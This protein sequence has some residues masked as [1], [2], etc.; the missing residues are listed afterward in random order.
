MRIGIL[1]LP[2]HTNYGGIL[3]AYALQTVLERMGHKVD[4]IGTPVIVKHLPLWRKILSVSK[5]LCQRY[6]LGRKDIL[7]D[8]E[9]EEYKRAIATRKYT[10]QF[11][12]KYIHTRKVYRLQEIQQND[13]DAII[14]GSDQ[15][16][17]TDY[18]QQWKQQN[19]DDVYLGFTKDW[20]L[21]RIAYAASFG[22]D[23]VELKG[24]ELKLCKEAISKFNAISV[25]EENGVN[26]CREIFGVKATVM[27]D[28][29]LL[30]SYDD[31]KKLILDIS[32][33][34]KPNFLLSYILDDNVEKSSLRDKIANEKGLMIKITNKSDYIDNNGAYPPQPPVEA[35]LKA[36]AECKYVITDSFHACVFSIIFHKQFTVIANKERGVSRFQTLLKMFGLTDRMVYSPSEYRVLQDIDFAK[37]DDI[38]KNKQEGALL[39]LRENLK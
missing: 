9:K 37:V 2:L 15:I 32:N 5:R 22:K 25:R 11:V 7:I 29:T 3:Q 33:T 16:W 39:F 35:W 18:N 12:D 36:F 24:K 31:Y 17:R 21:K 19:A 13:Y 4:V 23:K 10:T 6:L 28:P 26:L 14:V 27:P 34:S 38:I 8:R 1:T 30:L 20:C